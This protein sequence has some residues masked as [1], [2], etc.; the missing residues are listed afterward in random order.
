MLYKKNLVLNEDFKKICILNNLIVLIAE[1]QKI[2]DQRIFLVFL[3]NYNRFFY[4]FYPVFAPRRA[5]RI[6]PKVKFTH[7][8]DILLKEIVKEFGDS[9]WNLIASKMPSRNARQCRERWVNYLADNVN[10]SPFTPEEDLLLLQK[11]RDLGRRW[12]QI[13]KFFDNRTDISVKSRYLVLKRRNITLESL[14]GSLEQCGN[15]SQDKSLSPNYDSTVDPDTDE[16]D[17]IIE[18]MMQSHEEETADM[19]DF[20]TSVDF[21]V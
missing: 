20:D 15:R 6:H 8:E 12:V 3:M 10:R 14:K 1:K 21:W 19:I 13:S 9:D 7:D 4:G 16:T 2:L 17:R 18:E 11:H 5:Q